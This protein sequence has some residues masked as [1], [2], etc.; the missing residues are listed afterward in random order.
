MYA[1]H[2][3]GTV[4]HPHGSQLFEPSGDGDGDGSGEGEGDGSGDGDGDGSGEGDGPPPELQP[5]V[6][7][8]LWTVYTDV[9][10]DGTVPPCHR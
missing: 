5:H 3:V 9:P 6:L 1:A 7:A 10:S 2:A 4:K 8:P